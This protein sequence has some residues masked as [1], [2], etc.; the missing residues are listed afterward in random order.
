MSTQTLALSFTTLP[1]RP[2]SHQTGWRVVCTRLVFSRFLV[3]KSAV[4]PDIM[5][6]CNF[7]FPHCPS[8][9]TGQYPHYAW[10][11]SK[12]F[13]IRLSPTAPC[14]FTQTILSDELVQNRSPSLYWIPLR[15][16]LL[17]HTKSSFKFHSEGYQFEPRR[18]T[19]FFCPKP[20]RLVTW[21]RP[22]T[23]HLKSTVQNVLRISTVLRHLHDGGGFAK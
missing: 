1:L 8:Q 2:N 7:H 14:N 3:R 23:F 20:S 9:I 15:I 11:T 6:G 21:Y 12:S 22:M 13:G 18:D 10:V 17:Q 19:G 5:A 4:T 16:F